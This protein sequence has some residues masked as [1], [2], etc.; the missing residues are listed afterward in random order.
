VNA[1]NTIAAPPIRTIASAAGAMFSP[2]DASGAIAIF[3]ST[4]C[5]AN[6]NWTTSSAAWTFQ[7]ELSLAARGDNG[8]T[9]YALIID[10]A[11]RRR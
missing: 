6:A 1:K 8:R 2:P 9:H 3:P 10:N 11:V 7:R 4:A 5:E